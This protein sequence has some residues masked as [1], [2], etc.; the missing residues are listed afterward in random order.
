MAILWIQNW[1]AKD[2][3]RSPGEKLTTPG[4]VQLPMVPQSVSP[5]TCLHLDCPCQIG[6]ISVGG[7]GKRAFTFLS[8]PAPWG[9]K[10]GDQQ[11]NAQPGNKMTFTRPA[12]NHSAGRVIL[13]LS[14][15]FFSTTFPR[16]ISRHARGRQDTVP[17]KST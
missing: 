13:G 17:F 2:E 11:A 1:P 15:A 12:L 7:L 8:C 16:V 10:P 9:A 14:G 3:A 4:Q 6:P 5:W